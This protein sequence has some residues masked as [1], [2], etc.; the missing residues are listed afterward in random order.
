[1]P[2][3][4]ISFR[5]PGAGFSSQ[6]SCSVQVQRN[7]TVFLYSPSDMPPGSGRR[8]GHDSSMIPARVGFLLGQ[9]CVFEN[10]KENL[11]ARAARENFPKFAC[12]RAASEQ[13]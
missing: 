2:Y 1:M 5:E 9:T 13:I 7:N 8:P 6:Y 4:F 11:P 3:F 10:L 12:P